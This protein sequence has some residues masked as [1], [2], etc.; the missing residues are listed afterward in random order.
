MADGYVTIVRRRW[1]GSKEREDRTMNYEFI[2]MILLF[3]PV[4][5]VGYIFLWEWVSAKIFESKGEHT[6]RKC[7][8]TSELK[9]LYS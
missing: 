9:I 3:N 1:D 2:V 8:Y 5:L 7:L 6:I 4:S